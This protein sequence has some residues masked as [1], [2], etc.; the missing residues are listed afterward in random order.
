MEANRAVYNFYKQYFY[1]YNKDKKTY[2]FLVFKLIYF[3][4]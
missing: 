3:N 2:S 1:L 4:L